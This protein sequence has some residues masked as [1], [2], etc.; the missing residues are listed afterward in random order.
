M[1]SR[2]LSATSLFLALLSVVSCEKKEGVVKEGVADIDDLIVGTW[3]LTDYMLEAEV[4]IE[5]EDEDE[6]ERN[7]D[8]QAEGG[9]DM[10]DLFI[11]FHPDGTTSYSGVGFTLSYTISED[12]ETTTE[13]EM[14]MQ[15]LVLNGIWERKGDMLIVDNPGSGLDPLE[16]DIKSL[17]NNE[18]HLSATELNVLIP[19][20][21]V[22][23]ITVIASVDAHFVRANYS[24]QEE[25]TRVRGGIEEV[26]SDPIVGTWQ[27]WGHNW[28]ADYYIQGHHVEI[29]TYPKCKIPYN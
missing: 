22:G 23:D 1:K 20:P 24:A 3:Q 8:I 4:T 14:R 9:E 25:I 6:G 13:D 5:D 15:S 19:F 27:L 28:Y 10:G 12:G 26:F 21:E 16:I 29:V 11:T 7:L 17:T 2:I 18:L